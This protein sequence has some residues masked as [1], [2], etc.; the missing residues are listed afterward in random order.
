MW[1]VGPLGGGVPEQSPGSDPMMV[2]E[3]LSLGQRL[4]GPVVGLFF[5]HHYALCPRTVPK[6]KM[7]FSE[8]TWNE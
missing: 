3:L 7:T 1:A 6:T 8:E 4:L 2:P 5:T